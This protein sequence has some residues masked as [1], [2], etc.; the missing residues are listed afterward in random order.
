MKLEEYGESL[1]YEV[2]FWMQGLSNPSYPFEELGKLS[3]EVAEKL[4]ALAIIVLLTQGEPDYF[5]H[6][7]IRSG[8]ARET[9]LRKV[10][11]RSRFEDHD[12]CSGRYE[13]LLDSIAAGDFTLARS[14][15]SFSPSDFRP[16]HEYED[17]YAYAQ[18]LHRFLLPAPSGEEIDQLLA[19]WKSYLEDRRSARL[20]VCRA[21]NDI[22]Q[23]EFNDAFAALLGERDMKIEEDKKRGQLEEPHIVAQRRIFVEGLALLRLA[24]S[25]GLTTESEYRYCPSLARVLMGTPFPG[26]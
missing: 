8:R 7:L 11:Q 21:L 18:I 19:R 24:E 1:A 3:L 25:R 9:Y 17:D 4:R 26:E 14:I 5:F 22:K 2:A 6:N 20:S 13:P 12:Y 23:N 10:H 15:V 16:H